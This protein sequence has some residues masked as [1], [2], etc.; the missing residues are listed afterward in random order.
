[1][2]SPDRSRRTSTN[3][4]TPPGWS[5]RVTAPVFLAGRTIATVMI[6]IIVTSM[7]AAEP[8]RGQEPSDAQRLAELYAPIAMV[9]S[10][11]PPCDPAGPGFFPVPV[12]WIFGRE[13]IELRANAGGSVASDPVLLAG[14]SPQDLA[15]AGPNTY[16]DFPGDPASAGCDYLAYFQQAVTDYRLEPTTYARI[17]VDE[18][19][20]QLYLQYW[21]WYLFNDWNNLHESDWEM[22]QVVFDATTVEEALERGPVDVG[23][24]QHES[25]EIARWRNRKLQR[26]E[27][28]LVIYPAVG[29]HATY[30]G[31][32]LYISWGERGSGFG[33]D[34]TRPPHASMP[35]QPI[36][37]SEPIDPN[38]PFAWLLYQ[39]RWGQRGIPLF[40][41]PVGPNLTERWT[42]P[43]AASADWT[44]AALSVPDGP[45]VGPDPT[46]T[47]CSLTEYGSRI[48]ARAIGQPWFGVS[49]AGLLAIGL[50]YSAYRVRPYLLEALDVYGNEL[51]TFLGIGLV[52]IP[53]GFLFNVVLAALTRY[54]PFDQ[55]LGW[56]NVSGGAAFT[57]AS[58]VGGLQQAAMLLLVVPAVVEAM[59]CIRRGERPT[60]A[61]SYRASIRHVPTVLVAWAIYLVLIVAT[62]LS[63]VAFPFALY[64]GVTMQFFVQA[65]IL[66]GDRPGWNALLRSWRTTRSQ[67][68]RTL[69]RTL[70][71]LVLAVMPG[72]L[73]GLTFLILGG[74]RVQFANVASGFLYALLIPYAYIGL[75]LA[76]RRLRN[77]AIVEPQMVTSHPVRTDDASLLS[78]VPGTWR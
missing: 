8:A 62:T 38:G 66:N 77:E 50:V 5:I 78:D 43:A 12:D 49:L 30:P 72:P 7:V 28:H 59:Q 16:I 18:G 9:H 20:R 73:V 46:R 45:S 64:F 76:W 11:D 75:T 2:S 47:F 51:A 19:A 37:V 3:E 69:R 23:F 27:R 35:L 48:V 13:D 31:A 39:G 68:V 6:A 65:A 44:V 10:P 56:L 55:V 34:D 22:I 70:P 63:V 41:G 61:G 15:A 24:A 4:R 74:S 40:D 58:L 54:S 42:D 32:D 17:V 26:E 36:L 57:A 71:F 29:S 67:L 1:M 21:F 14:F 60:V 52:A 53:I 25:G 33:C